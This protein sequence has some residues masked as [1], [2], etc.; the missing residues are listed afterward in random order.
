MYFLND[1]ERKLLLRKLLPKSRAEA[2]VADEL[3]GWNWH[4][5]P[6]E[7]LYD[8]KLAV[9]EV[10]GQ[11]CSSGRD[12]FLRKVRGA[13]LI[14]NSEMQAGSLLHETVALALTSAKRLL[15]TYGIER[16]DQVLKDIVQVPNALISKAGVGDRR[17]YNEILVKAAWVYE[18]NSIASRLQSYLSRFPYISVD[19]LVTLALPIVLE[20]RL[21]G[22]FL[23]LSKGISTDA[24]V[25]SEPMVLDMKLGLPRPFHRLSTTGYA[26]AMESLYEFPVS[27]GCTVYVEYKNNR[28]H[29]NKDMY[30]ISDELRQWFIDSRDERMR[31]VVEEIDPGVSNNCYDTCP[32][33]TACKGV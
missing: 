25:F 3:R 16:V 9:Y 2:A 5:P 14:A 26:L 21:D 30:I 31:M 33:R 4:Q 19:S 13:K 18:Y 29:V 15:Y 27:L 1:E 6:L 12:L 7:P 23:G 20:Q 10:A 11:Y 24:Y 22:S 8:L 28:I 17:V 32:M